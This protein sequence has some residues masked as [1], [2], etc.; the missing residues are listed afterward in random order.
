MGQVKRGDVPCSQRTSQRLFPCRKR[1]KIVDTAR[2][3]KKIQRSYRRRLGK[4]GRGVF[5]AIDYA[6]RCL[7]LMKYKV[8]RP[9][10]ETFI[11]NADLPKKGDIFYISTAGVRTKQ[12]ERR[13]VF[14]FKE[15]NL[16]KK[17]TY[18]WVVVE[19]TRKEREEN[20]R[21]GRFFARPLELCHR[22]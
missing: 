12:Q 2:T 15:S 22:A 3:K 17:T 5:S 10:S 18:G 21:L 19:R 8:R 11:A 6:R 16:D 4:A 20:R 1:T 7:R 14:C 13:R 9:P